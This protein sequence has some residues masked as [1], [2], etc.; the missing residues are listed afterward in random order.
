MTKNEFRDPKTLTPAPWNPGD[1][2]QEQID[3]IEHSLAEFD[4]F[5]NVVVWNN[6]VIA[7]KGVH[8]ASLQH[9]MTELEV[10]DVSFLSE[11]EAKRLCLADRALPFGG[12][13]NPD[14]LSDLLQ[15][16]ESFSDIPGVTPDWMQEVMPVFPE[17]IFDDDATSSDGGALMNPGHSITF[18][19]YTH[20]IVSNDPKIQAFMLKHINTL[21][22]YA[23]EEL[24]Q[25]LYQALYE[26]LP[27][28]DK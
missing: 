6:L 21:S 20:K 4:Q 1:H 7:G 24:A 18:W 17:I 3:A 19:I 16:L 28:F 14:R 9:G 26:F 5:K 10:K 27:P 12:Q 2:P 8:A 25:I 23:D 15:E 13:T 11:E 22:H